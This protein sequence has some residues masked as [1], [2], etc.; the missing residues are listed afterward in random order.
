MNTSNICFSNGVSLICRE[1]YVP[2]TFKMENLEDCCGAGDG[3][4]NLLVPDSILGLRITAACAIHDDW[5]ENSDSTWADFHQ[6]NYIFFVNILT[7]IK[8]LSS[9][10]LKS[11]RM[12]LALVYFDAV[13]T[14]GAIVF[15]NLHMDVV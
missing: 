9:Q 10:W 5:F 14:L 13:D 11:I 1:G 8:E 4:G 15:K 7:I 12:H 2:P 3:L 6:G